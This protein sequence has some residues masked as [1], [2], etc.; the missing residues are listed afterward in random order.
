MEL[1]QVIQ[2]SQVEEMVIETTKGQQYITVSDKLK[3]I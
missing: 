1:S 2:K 3:N